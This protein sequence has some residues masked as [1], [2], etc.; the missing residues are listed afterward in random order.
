MQ[1]HG[2]VVGRFCIGHHSVSRSM[3]T[4]C[5]MHEAASFDVYFFLGERNVA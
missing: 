4:V 1:M 2:P 5:Q 3:R